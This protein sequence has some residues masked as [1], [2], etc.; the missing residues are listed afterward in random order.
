MTSAQIAGREERFHPDEVTYLSIGDGATSEGEFWES[1]NTA[2]MK[3]LPILYLV[4]DNG[5]AISVPV[6][7]QTPGGNIARLVSSFP[8][9]PCM[10]VDGTDFLPATRCMRHGGRPIACRRGPR[11]R[12]RHGHAP[13]LAL[14]LGR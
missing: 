11:A 8:T 13:L 10:E 9:S 12:A 3:R 4:E 7:V 14:A 2:C 1:L 5:Y 6:D